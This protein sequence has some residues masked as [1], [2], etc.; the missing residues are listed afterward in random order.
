MQVALYG[1][2]EAGFAAQQLFVVGAF[3]SLSWDLFDFV[4]STIRMTFPNK[5]YQGA[6]AFKYWVVLPV[7]HHITSIITVHTPPL[8]SNPI[9]KAPT[10]LVG[11]QAIRSDICASSTGNSVV[12]LQAHI[13]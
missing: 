2:S 6:H 9:L 12:A 7:M 5:V 11:N 3:A 4:N 1:W 13:A 10:C 8:T